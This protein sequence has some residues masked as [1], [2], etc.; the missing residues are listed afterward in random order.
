[1]TIRTRTIKDLG[2]SPVDSS[3]SIPLNQQIYMDLLNLIIYGQLMPDDMLPP[4]MELARSYKVSRQTVR[5]ALSRLHNENLIQRTAGRGTI[6]LDRPNRIQ[7]FLGR[8]ITQQVLEMGRT[9]HSQVLQIRSIM[10]DQKSPPTLLD[11]IGSQALELVRL[12]FADKDPVG[13]QYTTV[14]TNDCPDLIEHDF[15]V[16]SLYQILMTEYNLLIDSVEHTVNAISADEW[17]QS[18]FRLTRPAPLLQVCTTTYLES[19][20]PIECTTSIYKPDI[21]EFKFIHKYSGY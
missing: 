10:I 15:E 4:E 21:Y 19:G 2:I 1:M 16:N 9:P 12:R 14:I 3:I 6:V 20:D 17:H 7:F 18:L 11:K 13:I 5:D 8:S